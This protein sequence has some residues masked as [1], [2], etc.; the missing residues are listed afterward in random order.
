MGVYTLNWNGRGY[1]FENS[2]DL[3]MFAENMARVESR[4]EAAAGYVTEEMQIP[5][6]VQDHLYWKEQIEQRR[7]EDN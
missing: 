1:S 5:R 6:E 7:Q 3:A 4:R 2:N